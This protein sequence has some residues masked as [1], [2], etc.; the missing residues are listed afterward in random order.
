MEKKRGKRELLKLAM[1]GYLQTGTTVEKE[2]EERELLK[3]SDNGDGALA[4]TGG[5]G[6]GRA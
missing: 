4:H 5:K 6:V 2:R 3:H 1:L